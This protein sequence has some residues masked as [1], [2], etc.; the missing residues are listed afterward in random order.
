MFC[1]CIEITNCLK[2]QYV[3]LINCNIVK[4]YNQNYIYELKIEN[5]NIFQNIGLNIDLQKCYKLCLTNVNFLENENKF[6]I[7][8]L[9][10]LICNLPVSPFILN[11]VKYL[12][13]NNIE[14]NYKNN[15]LIKNI[16][17]ILIEF[18]YLNNLK[19][20]YFNLIN[21]LEWETILTKKENLQLMIDDI[22]NNNDFNN[23]QFNSNYISKIRYFC[24]NENDNI[25]LQCPNI[26]ELNFNLTIKNL[27]TFKNLQILNLNN[28]DFNN[29]I[30]LPLL[31]ELNLIYCKD[32]SIDLKNFPIIER[33]NIDCK[34]LDIIIDN[35]IEFNYLTY[36][37]LKINSSTVLNFNFKLK[38]KN[39]LYFELINNDND[40]KMKYKVELLDISNLIYLNIE[41]PFYSNIS[42][43]MITDEM[44]TDDKSKNN[45][46]KDKNNNS[47]RS[48]YTRLSNNNNTNNFEQQK[49]CFIQ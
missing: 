1:D 42:N 48:D 34:A 26:T 3:H 25:V 35:F 32:C 49:K 10:N 17:D 24:K 27:N 20:K 44:M 18:K 7:L 15:H 19:I 33:V 36:F 47:N 29:N 38:A 9:N 21:K 40:K 4:I 5:S 14:I 12:N 11:D 16:F 22:L 30:Q 13:I 46:Q 2:L 43:A 31:K 28:C 39:L 23:L 6:N 8:E 37:K 41:L 45:E